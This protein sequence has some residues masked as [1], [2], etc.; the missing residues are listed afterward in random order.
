MAESKIHYNIRILV[1]KVEHIPTKTEPMHGVHPRQDV[2][3]E[4]RRVVTDAGKIDLKHTDFDIAKDLAAKHLALLTE[5]EGADP[6]K[7]NTRDF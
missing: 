2:V 1:E 3:V 6:R 4:S 5:F 7:G